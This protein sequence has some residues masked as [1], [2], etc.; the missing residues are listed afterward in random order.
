MCVKMCVGNGRESDNVQL[1]DVCPA[2]TPLFVRG[3]GVETNLEFEA[4]PTVV[5]TAGMKDPDSVM[6]GES[7]AMKA[8]VWLSSAQNRMRLCTTSMMQKR[9]CSL[10]RR[11]LGNST[12][13][14]YNSLHRE[15][16]KTQGKRLLV[17]VCLMVNKEPEQEGE[18]MCWPKRTKRELLEMTLDSL[19][20]YQLEEKI[21]YS[22]NVLGHAQK[23]TDGSRIKAN[24]A[25]DSVRVNSVREA[26]QVVP[27]TSIPMRN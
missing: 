8:K 2:Q 14:Q 17:T 10:V 15:S 6:A 18:L 7:I 4:A 21:E 26:R 19:W 3:F 25:K 27:G 9:N 13:K 12:G 20:E 1:D 23:H 5:R 16:W 22:F 24:G 11:L